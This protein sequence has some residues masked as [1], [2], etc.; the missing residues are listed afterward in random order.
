E[1][2]LRD[3][4]GYVH[5]VK[6]KAMMSTAGNPVEK[7]LKVGDV[8]KAG[9]Q[10]YTQKKSSVSITFDFLKQNAVHI[11]E[12][13]RAVFTSIE[14][15]DIKLETGSVFSAVDGLPKDSTWKVTTPVAVAAVRGTLYVVR[16]QAESGEFYAATVDVPDD[17]RDSAIEI[18]LITADNL[19]SIMEGKQITLREGDSSDLQEMIQD[20]NPEAVKEIQ[21]FFNEIKG[22]QQKTLL[23]ALGGYVE[24]R[25]SENKNIYAQS[26][27]SSRDDID[28]DMSE[29]AQLPLID[30][31]PN[32][33]PA[34]DFKDQHGQKDLEN[35][36]AEPKDQDY[37]SMSS[38]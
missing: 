31:L 20:L 5:Q 38:S 25:V 32:L 18:N 33:D 3:G 4:L 14:P 1:P 28:K 17:G 29:T 12:S 6:G 26:D 22:D 16:F 9:D 23:A 13:S 34:E 11:P 30:N 8:V 35:A 2:T 21:Q 10:I 15:T 19:A 37:H 36:Q 7:K 24:R 27:Y